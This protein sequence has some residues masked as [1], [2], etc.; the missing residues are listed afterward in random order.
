MNIHKDNN[1]YIIKIYGRNNISYIKIGYS[2][3]IIKRLTTYYYHNPLIEI[4]DCCFLEDGKSWELEFHK[5][6]KSSLLNEWYDSDYL[7][8]ILTL[9]KSSGAIFNKYEDEPSLD[10]KL[11]KEKIINYNNYNSTNWVLDKLKKQEYSYEELEELFKEDFKN[12]GITF[13]G[14]TIKDYFPEFEKVRRTRNK[15][16]QTYYKFKI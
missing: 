2:S 12:K 1:I 14:F 5:N 16:K 13:N 6:N 15:I 4:I 9:L 8:N 10:I 11:L 3:N 7:E